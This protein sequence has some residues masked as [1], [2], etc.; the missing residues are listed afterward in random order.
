MEANADPLRQSPPEAGLRITIKDAVKA[1]LQDEEAR[2]LAKTTTCR[3]KTLFEQQL[4]TWAKSESLG[5]L[6]QLTTA[7]LRE[8]RASWKNG[9]TLYFR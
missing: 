1:F 2:Q 8:F 5:F 3:S 9:G 6:D 7:R 4:L